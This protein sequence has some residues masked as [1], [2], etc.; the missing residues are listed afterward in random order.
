[1]HAS[2][3]CLRTCQLYEACRFM[4]VFATI[5]P[6]QVNSHTARIK[7]EYRDADQLRAACLALGW[8]WL[9]NGRHRLYAEDVSGLGFKIPGWTYPCVVTP[10]GQLAYDDFNG[11]WG[12][13]AD[14]DKLRAAYAFAAAEQRAQE[15]GWQTERTDAGLLIYHPQGGTLTVDQTGTVATTGFTGHACHEARETLGISVDPS[16][17][18]ATVEA[19]KTQAQIELPQ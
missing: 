18:V 8:E 12:N 19:C 15:L 14:L 7:V 6:T 1:M 4:P 10:S 5:G 16:S 17:I 13:V 3:T 11:V 9:G 2:F